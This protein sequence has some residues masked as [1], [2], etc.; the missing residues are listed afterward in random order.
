[1]HLAWQSWQEKGEPKMLKN[2]LQFFYRFLTAATFRKS[3]MAAA[4][5]EKRA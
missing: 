3:N 1:M 4:P 5:V 2:F